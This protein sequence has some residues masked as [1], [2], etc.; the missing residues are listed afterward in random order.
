MGQAIP[1][2]LQTLPYPE[3]ELVSSTHRIA[4]LISSL[5]FTTL[6]WPA[7]L[8]PKALFNNTKVWSAHF[9]FTPDQYQGLKPVLKKADQS[10]E[11][12]SR[13]QAPEGLR[14]GI[15]G[16]QGMHFEYVG[17]KLMFGDLAL[18]NVAVRYKGNGTFRRGIL[19]N[20]VSLKVDLNKN[21][22]GQKLAGNTKLNFNNS[23]SD[24]SWMNEVLAY[25][26]YRDAKV[27]ASQ[28]SYSRVFITV[29][30]Q[31]AKAYQGLFTVVEEV[32]D[33][34]AE[35]H[36][37]TKDGLFFKPVV[38]TPFNYLGEDWKRYNQIYDPKRTPTEKEQRRVI[39]FSKIVTSANDTVFAARVGEFVDLDELARY[40]AVTVWLTSYDGIL[41]SGQNYY[42]YL[43][44]KT[45]KFQ[46]LPWDLDRA[47]G[48][49]GI[50]TG[51]AQRMN[52]LEP[53]LGPNRFLERIFKVPA[54]RSLY[55]ARMN[56]FSNTIFKPERFAQQVDEIA[57]A[58]RPAIV[59]ESP[60]LLARFD[61]AASGKT[62]PDTLDRNFGLPHVP[63]KTF[64]QGRWRS[65]VEQLSRAK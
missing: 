34:F 1:P 32:D 41:D 22:K 13:F 30:G 17:A 33:R 36:F 49:Y 54:F 10:G 64:T 65:V 29:P 58:I 45:Q 60:V 15:T 50:F 19:L 38:P 52:I 12:L 27:P 3:D 56:E 44:P 21:V 2:A 57:A 9:T 55:L 28:T 20:K 61:A 25:R 11:R 7:D 47:F 48:Q 42:L 31:F 62:M 35:E 51:D 14:N 59:E 23:V 37:G 4:L 24:L 43:D 16:S 18:D 6:A 40:L 26:L 8:D 53:W 5:A 63:I 46:F 39:D